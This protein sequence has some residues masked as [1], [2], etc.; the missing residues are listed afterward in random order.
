MREWET[1]TRVTQ[2]S[3]RYS[4]HSH[5]KTY[6]IKNSLVKAKQKEKSEIY[7][8]N[9]KALIFFKVHEY[10]KEMK[11]RTWKKWRDCENDKFEGINSEWMI[12]RSQWKWIRWSKKMLLRCVLGEE[13]N[14]TLGLI[15]LARQNYFYFFYLKRGVVWR[16]NS[17]QG[18][19]HVGKSD[20][21]F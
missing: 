10:E 6:I 16:Y 11:N 21:L 12:Y 15:L 20:L 1:K 13:D 8:V 14:E 17:R 9:H 19:S 3:S 7:T 18:K 2:K 5:H 4:K